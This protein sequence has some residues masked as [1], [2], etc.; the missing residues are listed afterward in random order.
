M[1]RPRRDTLL[2]R[3]PAPLRKL[4]GPNFL[5]LALL[6]AALALRF[7]GIDWD[8]GHGFHP[9]ERS[10]YL[11]AEDMFRTLKEAPGYEVWINQWPGMESGLPD[12][13]TALS[14]ERSP[15]N[16]H[17]FPLGSVLIYALVLIRSV[18]ELFTDWG[19]L[20]MRFAGRALT[21]LA[22][23]ASVWLMYVIGRRMYGR[24]TGILAAALTT[25]AVIHIQHAHFYRPEPFTVLTSLA[26]TWAMLRFIDTKRTRDAVL[27]GA[28]VG[29]AMA[30]KVS[31]APIVAP[32]ALT[33]LWVCKDRAGWRW[34]DLTVPVAVRFA[35]TVLLA[36]SAALAAYFITTPYAF[37]D[38]SQMLSDIQEQSRMVRDAFVMPFTRQYVDTPA[39]WYQIRQTA[40]WGLGLPLGIV[41]WLAAPFTAWMAWRG[42]ITQRAD[43]LLLAWA[44]PGFIFLELFEVKFLRYVFPLMPFYVLMAARMLIAAVSGARRLRQNARPVASEP[45]DAPFSEEWHATPPTVGDDLLFDEPLFGD[46]APFSE[47]WH[48]TPPVAGVAVRS[49][50]PLAPMRSI[51]PARQSPQG[52]FKH[53]ASRYAYP[54]SIAV[55]VVVLAGTVLYALA[56]AGIYSRSHT[57]VLASEWINANVPPGAS[58]INGGSHWDERI[59]DLG[60]YDVWTFPAYHPDSDL[61]KIP[62]LVDRLAAG[63]YVVFYSNRAYGSVARLPE[64]YPQSSAF[65]RLL[66]AGDLGYHLERAFTS[67]PSLAG[68]QLR[69]DPYGRA[70]LPTPSYDSSED[71]DKPGGLIIN[72]G[73]ADENVIGYDHPR[74]LVFRNAGKLSAADLRQ[75]IDGTVVDT[76]DVPPLMLPPGQLQA[77]QTGGTWSEAFD[78]DGWPNRIPWLTWLLAVELICLVAFPFTWWLLRPLP[79]RGVLFARLV[80]LLLVAWVVWMLVNAGLLR[81]SAG[82]VWL[83]LLI[84]AAPSAVVLWRQW[85]PMLDWL[86]EHWRLVLT[87]EALFLLA[88][89]AFIVIRAANPDLWHPWRGGEKPMELAYFTAVARSSVLPPYDP[90]FSG[91]YLNY[92]YWGYFILSIPLRITGIPPTTAFNLAVPLLF[93][94]TAT[95]AGSLAYNMVAVARGSANPARS[96]AASFPRRRLSRWLIGIG[97]LIRRVPT[98]GAAVAGLIAALMTVVAGNLDG[99]VQLF[100]MAKARSQGMDAALSNFDFWRSSRAIPEIEMFE[101]SLLTPWLETTNHSEMA[102]HIT[103]FPFFTFL[104]ADLHAHMMTLPFALLALAVGFAVLVGLT[105]SRLRSLWPWV[106]IATLGL[107]VGSLWAINSWEY[108]AYALLMLG[109]VA[110]AAWMLPGPLKSRLA[111]AAVLAVPAL[112]VS[113]A[114]FLPFHSATETFGTGIEPTRWR[115]PLTNYLLIHALPL[116]TAAALLAA[117]LPQ[118]WRPLVRRMKFGTRIPAIHQWLLVAVVFGIL[119][120]CYFWV[121]GFLTA[122]AL[123]VLLTL[124]GWALAA[125]LVSDADSPP[126][127]SDVM[128]LS[129]LA[130]ALAVGIGVDF[131]RVEGDIARMNT[132][133][134][135]YLVAWILFAVAG[136]YGFWRGWTAMSWSGKA[137][138]RKLRWAAA[139]LVGLTAAGVLVYPALAT[140]VRIDD[141]FNS[142]PLTLDGEAWMSQATYHPPDWCADK[143]TEPIAMH[144]DYD[145]I[146][147]LQDNAIG[148]PVILE[149][150]GAQYCWNSRFSQYTGLPTV[151]GWPWHQTQQRNDGDAVRRRANDVATIYN[152]RSADTALDLL[153][154]YNVTYIVV[155]DLERLYHLPD[156]IAKFEFMVDEGT[157]TLAYANVGTAI[158]QV[159]AH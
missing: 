22:D 151:I 51:A 86:R 40:V 67:Y 82:A 80:G 119:L 30:P 7:Y 84:V 41:A 87:A 159:A 73:Y 78:R 105:R 26:A 72:L 134:K 15:L 36:G 102:F 93:A 49:T 145:A 77:Q 108:P 90:W 133:F 153:D 55:L 54:I 116:L 32:L 126:R 18:A 23:V 118:A 8:Q 94:F 148:T 14:A 120:A 79:D 129:M 43:L 142:T 107:A 1:G 29:L 25:F 104:F 103:E 75:R 10:F 6:A 137:G 13:R 52:R 11:R 57:A 97:R 83:S 60:R 16:P 114:A 2:L 27:L 33:F 152:T 35:P 68:V 37:L 110:A 45:D 46:D 92:Y 158:Y 147:W 128:A 48:A 89:L 4:W 101:P 62:E 59:P 98:S 71:R 111:V 69:D 91:G 74:V 135:Y 56:F 21:A 63:D 157:L 38:Y 47:E 81:F 154:R 124:T 44:I 139:A 141:R 100:E 99:P 64:Q 112:L 115:T 125:T 144:W 96:T 138:W 85:R 106:T 113:Y 155:G 34:S 109:L 127:R 9:D 19:A 117:T 31:V 136:A 17:W 149:A 42:G 53:Y 156:G 70:G 58:I 140:P 66:F 3:I 131:I 95:G 28:L 61:T 5:L 143:P 65:L 12:F 88:Y 123:T 150:H 39:F 132:L 76:A 122:G 130:V 121:A 20:D 50:P 146:R 24:W